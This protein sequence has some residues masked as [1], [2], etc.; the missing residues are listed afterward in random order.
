[1]LATCRICLTAAIVLGCCLPTWAQG[2]DLVVS[3]VLTKRSLESIV[4]NGD[5]VIVG[6]VAS[7][8]AE[9]DVCDV[10]LTGVETIR[11][12]HA[13]EMNIRLPEGAFSAARLKLN[14][15]LQKNDA[16]E[17]QLAGHLLLVAVARDPGRGKDDWT[18]S[19]AVDLS[20]ENLELWRADGTQLA[21]AEEILRAA[22][23][24]IRR[25]PGVTRIQTFTSSVLAEGNGGVPMELLLEVPVDE[26]LETRLQVYIRSDTSSQRTE[27]ARGLRFFKTETNIRLVKSLL[28]DPDFKFV[29][30]NSTNDL[31]LKSYPVRD[32]AAETLRY[33]GIK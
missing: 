12:E 31:I 27:G 19:G 18:A 10:T 6:E 1:M 17:V 20:A 9:S 29:P 3:R 13:E 30:T 22:R 23:G 14:K 16:A 21:N 8:R 11:G 25:F 5:A 2:V 24:T 7:F 15:L 33:W 4:L 32:A 28:D 26:R